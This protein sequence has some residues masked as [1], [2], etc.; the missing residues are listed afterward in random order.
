MYS[1][2][3][4][5]IKI[6]RNSA[7]CIVS[8]CNAFSLFS[9]LPFLTALF[10]EQLVLLKTMLPRKIFCT[11]ADKHTVRRIRHDLSGDADRVKKMSDSCHRPETEVFAAHDRSIEFDHTFFIGKPAEPDRFHVRISLDLFYDVFDP[12][13]T[14]PVTGENTGC[15]FKTG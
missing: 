8:L 12:I 3:H 14:G 13:D 1:A 9:F 11:C 7:D 6:E 5:S 10:C 2:C 4:F 15:F